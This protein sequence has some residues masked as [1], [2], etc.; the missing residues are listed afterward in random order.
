MVYMTYKQYFA[1]LP[2]DAQRAARARKK[3]RH[4]KMWAEF[5]K[6]SGPLFWLLSW[7]LPFRWWISLKEGE[8][9]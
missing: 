6:D 2:R 5:R 3:K 9:Q 4:A 7:V 8:W 1:K